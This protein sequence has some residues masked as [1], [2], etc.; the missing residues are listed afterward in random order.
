[1]DACCMHYESVRD[2]KLESLTT[3]ESQ[4]TL[5]Y[6]AKKKKYQKLLE[7]ASKLEESEVPKL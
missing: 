5:L 7:V 2:L 1:M 4:K 3:F 6:A